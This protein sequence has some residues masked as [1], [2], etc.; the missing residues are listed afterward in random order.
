[1]PVLAGTPG[2]VL[3]ALQA[4]QTDAAQV[5]TGRNWQPGVI[6]SRVRKIELLHQCGWISV[7]QLCVYT[8]VI[9]VHKILQSKQPQYL[10]EKLTASSRMQEVNKTRQKFKF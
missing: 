10:Y 8:S 4:V 7:Q 9:E 6:P 1:M 3:V 5:I 2:Y